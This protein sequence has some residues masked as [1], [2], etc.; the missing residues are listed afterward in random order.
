[1]RQIVESSC[2]YSLEYFKESEE[3]EITFQK[4]FNTVVYLFVPEDL[5]NDFLESK[6]KAHFTIKESK[7]CIHHL[8]IK[9][10][11]RK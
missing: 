9:K 4:S 1:M 11:L 10:N 6:S 7:D 2:I 5:Y 3:L 8:K